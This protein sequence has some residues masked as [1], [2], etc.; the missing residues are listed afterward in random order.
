MGWRQ[1]SAL[2]AINIFMSEILPRIRRIEGDEQDLFVHLGLRP[3]MELNYVT[4]DE[5]TLFVKIATDFGGFEI[6]ASNDV[7]RLNGRVEPW[8]YEAFGPALLLSDKNLS[9]LLRDCREARS[10]SKSMSRFYYRGRFHVW[11]D[12]SS[13]PFDDERGFRRF[14]RKL[15]ELRFAAFALD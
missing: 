1:Q 12:D 10:N 9:W 3:W 11:A 6:G 14:R 2:T 7:E 15:E 4:A 5:I 13:A 8:E